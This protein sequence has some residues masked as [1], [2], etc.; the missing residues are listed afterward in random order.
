MTADIS[1]VSGA[2]RALDDTILPPPQ[3]TMWDKIGKMMSREREIDVVPISNIF[4][5]DQIGEVERP[6]S[7]ANASVEPDNQALSTTAKVSKLRKVLNTI[8]HI[9]KHHKTELVVGTVIAGSIA[10][11]CV[12]AWPTIPL[13]GKIGLIFFGSMAQLGAVISHNMLAP[14]GQCEE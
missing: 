1:W 2:A 14:H 4:G 9:F 5:D 7:Q 10:A 8:S 12:L 3:E 11:F 13:L 6:D